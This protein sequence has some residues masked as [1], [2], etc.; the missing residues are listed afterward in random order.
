M[1]V[2]ASKRTL[3]FWQLPKK[4]LLTDPA[5]I[6]LFPLIHRLYPYTQLHYAGL[7]QMKDVIDDIN[8][9]KVAGALVEL[10]CG[11]GGCGAFMARMLWR[12]G[13]LREIHLFDSFEGLSDPAVEDRTGSKKIAEKIQKGYL[14]VPE[15]SVYEALQVVPEDVRTHVHLHKGWFEQTVPQAK[16][17]VGPIAVLRLDADLYEPTLFSLRELYD[18]VVPGG[19]IVIDDYKN[20]IGAR[21]ALFEF[22]CEKNI[23]PYVQEYP[24]GG[25][26]YFVKE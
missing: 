17:D 20:W 9:R 14:Q 22:F 26:A 1:A 8:R 21:K 13:K 6:L 23:S 16:H 24:G 19:Y 15:E 11:R 25:V 5:K 10:G 7:C 12:S 2:Y 3:K 18:A 4:F